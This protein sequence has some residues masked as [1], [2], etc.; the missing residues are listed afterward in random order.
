M[1]T[2]SDTLRH[3]ITTFWFSAWFQNMFFSF[4]MSSRKIT[5]LVIFVYFS[6]F[7]HAVLKRPDLSTALILT[8]V[9][10]IVTEPIMQLWFWAP[11]GYGVRFHPTMHRTSWADGLME[12][13]LA[14]KRSAGTWSEHPPSYTSCI[15]LSLFN[16]RLMCVPKIILS[17]SEHNFS[18]NFIV[19]WRKNKTN[20]K[21]WN[22]GNR[23]ELYENI[24][25][26]NTNWATRTNQTKTIKLFSLFVVYPLR[27]IRTSAWITAVLF[28]HESQK[29]VK[30][31]PVTQFN[32]VT[33]F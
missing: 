20:L 3:K 25:N 18:W 10:G 32:S 27:F 19:P 14:F 26:I 17:Q 24:Y 1:L 6:L 21:Q 13:D 31:T 9:G 22:T 11:A 30:L 16:C 5:E 28:P 23:I 2:S 7:S 8:L 15:I 4:Y 33:I 29:K 12:A